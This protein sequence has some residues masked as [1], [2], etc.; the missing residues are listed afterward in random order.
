M[1]LTRIAINRNS[2]GGIKLLS[3]PQAMHAAVEGCYPPE[4]NPT[5]G[6]GRVLWR[7][8]TNGPH[9]HLHLTAEAKPDPRSLIEQA[10]WPASDQ[11]GFDTRDYSEPL[12]RLTAGDRYQFRLA[13]NPQ[14]GI[15]YE[16]AAG[17]RRSG[18]VPVRGQAKL[19]D[20]L[21]ARAEKVGVAF[22]AIAITANDAVT[23]RRAKDSPSLNYTVFTGMLTVTDPGILRAALTA[24]IGH[25][26][27][28]G[29]GLM[30]LS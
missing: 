1:H 10:G 17:V 20:W 29:C 5:S 18:R 25:S 26:R 11:P 3:N 27:A 28:H 15:S 2:R 14:R 16:T 4:A 7:V 23:V 24:G 8:D 12:S 30:T 9:T 21:G 6:P 13:A 22:A 19:V